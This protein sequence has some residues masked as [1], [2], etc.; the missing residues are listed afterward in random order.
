MDFDGQASKVNLDLHGGL[1]AF[2]FIEELQASARWRSRRLDS[3]RRLRH[4]GTL[5]YCAMDM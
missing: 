1:G 4:A 5:T 2:G 3:L